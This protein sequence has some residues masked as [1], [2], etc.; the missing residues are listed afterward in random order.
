[1][2]ILVDA[3][4]VIRYVHP[5]TTFFPSDEPRHAKENEAFRALEVAV[6]EVIAESKE[7]RE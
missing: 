3:K 7:G 6:A 1:V 2:S 4:G 5:G